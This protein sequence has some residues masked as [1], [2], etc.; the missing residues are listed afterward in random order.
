MSRPEESVPPSAAAEPPAHRPFVPASAEVPELTP[1]PVVVGALLGILFGASSMYLVL[2]VGVTVSASIPVAVLSITIFR[3]FS[4]LFRVRQAT[5]LENNVVQTTGSAGESIAF[6]VGVT[7]PALLILGYDLQVGHV[8]L[9][10]VLGGLLGILMMI[11][12]RRALIVKE[13]RTLVYPEGTAC[14][15][16]LVTGER[17]ATT[18]KIVFAGLGAGALFALGYKALALF[19]DI[20]ERVFGRWFDGA[21]LSLEVGPELL[22][23]GYIIGT[24]VAL[25]MGAGGILSALVL[26]PAIKLFGSTAATPIFPATQLIRDMTPDDV[27]HQYILYIGAGA[28]AAGGIVSLARA[29]PTIVGGAARGLGSLRG[30][31]GGARAARPRT[32]RDLPGWLVGAGALALVVACAL[33]PSLRI[34]VLGAI[35][36]VA[37]GFL[38][39]TVS[40]RLTGEIGSSSNPISGMTVATLLL[41]SLIFLALGWVSARDKVAALSVAAVVCIAASNGGTTSQDLKTGYLV[42][43]TPS[44]QQIAILIGTLSSALVIGFVLLKLNDASTVFARRDYPGFRADVATLPERARLTGPDAGLDRAEYHVLRLTEPRGGVPAG[45]YLVDD[46]GRIRW[47]EDPGINGSVDRREGGEKVS[48]FSAPKAMLMSFIIDGIMSQRLPWGLVLLGVCIAIVL[49][50]C[51]LSSLAF[52][53]GVYL[54]LSTSAPIMVGGV[55]RALVGRAARVETEAEA[56]SGPGVLFSSGLIA[57]ASVAGMAVALAQLTE[58]TRAL[59]AA[60]NLGRLAPKFAQS[61][62]VALALFAGLGGILWL[63]G[64]GRLLRSP[65]VAAVPPGARPPAR[66][67]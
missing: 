4:R 18:G 5:I 41:T 51:G 48:K 46:A 23:V 39:V 15:Q 3:A 67:P 62:G 10:S 17:G 24:R 65:A 38:F 32:D 60:V 21:S 54:P 55:V 40:S 58:P 7:M 20:P 45:K 2:K 64:T 57:G 11:P 16:V 61:D 52:A 9:V 53:V 14:A 63:V 33:A 22:G 49:E 35:L 26:T 43:A 12:L 28:V 50:L 30:G 42:G 34:N 56:E 47:L 13:A 1:V 29:L 66:R 36:V 44:R 27:W 6:G 31:A 37:F 8:I 25:T 59:L 19:K